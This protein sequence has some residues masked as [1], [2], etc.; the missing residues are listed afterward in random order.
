MR[1]Y[2]WWANHA[3]DG[4]LAMQRRTTILWRAG[5]AA[6]R[7]CFTWDLLLTMANCFLFL[8]LHHYEALCKPPVPFFMEFLE[9]MFV[10]SCFI[11][12]ASCWWFNEVK[13]AKTA[14]WLHLRISCAPREIPDADLGVGGFWDCD[15]WKSAQINARA[16]YR[17]VFEYWKR[18]PIWATDHC[19]SLI[20]CMHS[21]V[22][23]L[24]LLLRLQQ[25]VN[26]KSVDFTNPS[27]CGWLWILDSARFSKWAE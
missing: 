21:V 4:H 20:F 22:L 13:G 10:S 16:Q 24:L 15:W 7:V 17:P 27:G 3:L 19:H 25:W 23:L 8:W 14:V 26:W 2:L 1:Q 11:H 18:W 9:N 6:E 12:F 5:I